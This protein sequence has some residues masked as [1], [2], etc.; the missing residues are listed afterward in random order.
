M[1]SSKSYPE[2]GTRW[3]IHDYPHQGLDIATYP[4][5]YDWLDLARYGAFCAREEGRPV[6]DYQRAGDIKYLGRTPLGAQ[7]ADLV[8][9]ESG[10]VAREGW[11]QTGDSWRAGDAGGSEL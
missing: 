10:Y 2:H 3:S 8:R 9:S 6:A 11:D 1:Y 7:V 4:Y 5:D